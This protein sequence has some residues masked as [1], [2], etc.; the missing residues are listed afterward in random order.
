[1]L[2]KLSLAVAVASASLSGMAFAETV[3]TA[4]GKLDVTMT[5]T[6]AT[7]WLSRG[8]VLNSAPTVQGSLDVAHES[9]LYVGVWGGSMSDSAGGSEFDYY[10]GYGR[11]ITEDV[12]FDL[13][14]AAYT[15][16]GSYST[17]DNGDPIDLKSDVEYLASVGAY[18]AT[19]GVK[20]RTKEAEQLYTYV[21]YDLEL[22]AG[23]GLSAAVGKTQYDD[24]ADGDDYVDWSLGVSKTLAGLDLNLTYASTDLDKVECG[25]A[26]SCENNIVFSVS[27]TF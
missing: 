4:V 19:V 12:S 11:D 14:V 18:G 25:S 6:L 9:G 22:P 13:Q 1:M 21:G 10:V 15:Y 2:K 27:K 24:K 16:P 3:E 5:A 7:D 26:Y 23:F 20:Y 8:I 17:D